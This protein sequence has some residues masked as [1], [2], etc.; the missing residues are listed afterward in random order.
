MEGA[1]W[2]CA[3]V[4][5]MPSVSLR[6]HLILDCTLTPYNNMIIIIMIIIIIIMII[7]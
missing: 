6:K 4:G 1:S 5:S 3:G 2:L 7:Q